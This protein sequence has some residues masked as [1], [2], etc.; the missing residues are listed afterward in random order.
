MSGE[1]VSLGKLAF[2]CHIYDA[3]TDYGRSLRSFRDEVGEKLDLADGR[4]RLALLDWL[5]AWTCRID[6]TMLEQL[7]EDLAPWYKQARS[8]LPSRDV[9]LL[10]LTPADLDA[11]ASLFDSLSA[12]RPPKARRRF[13][14]TAASK[15]LFALC[16]GVFVPWDRL[17]REKLVDGKESGTA[18]V[19]FLKQM[20]DDLR[21]LAEEWPELGDGLSKL[22][23]TISRPGTTAAQLVGEYYWAKITKKVERPNADTL[24]KWLAWG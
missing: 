17:I 7:A 15:T 6:L 2:A 3:M 12:I 11:F 24:K 5:N 23:D 21:L 14:P 22:P 10:D 16:P 9:R 18:Y 1:R 19:S 4:Q 8:T 13:G 20:R